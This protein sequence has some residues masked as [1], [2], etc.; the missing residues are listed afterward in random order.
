MLIHIR[1]LHQYE[2]GTEAVYK[3]WLGPCSC[4]AFLSILY[5]KLSMTGCY[6][7]PYNH[8]YLQFYV[9]EGDKNGTYLGEA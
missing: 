8:C 9:K 4:H 2:C 7:D 6:M 3:Q 5:C 1:P